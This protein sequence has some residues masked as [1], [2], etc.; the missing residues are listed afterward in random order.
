MQSVMLRQSCIY[1]TRQF[2]IEDQGWVAWF[3]IAAV[4]GKKITIYGDGKQTRGVLHVKDLVR[5][6]EAAFERK[7]AVAGQA[8]NIGGGPTNIMS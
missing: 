5:A 3:I 1:G 4:L 2:G 7:E 6:Y 8:F